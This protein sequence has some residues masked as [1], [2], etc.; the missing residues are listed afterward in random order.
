MST[1]FRGRRVPL[2]REDSGLCAES[3]SVH[4]RC[5]RDETSRVMQSQSNWFDIID[6]EAE[7]RRSPP[8]RTP[9]IPYSNRSWNS[10]TKFVS[11][12]FDDPMA[13]LKRTC[14]RLRCSYSS[15]WVTRHKLITLFERG[16][17]VRFL[18]R[19]LFSVPYLFR[20]TSVSPHV[21]WRIFLGEGSK[22][23]YHWRKPLLQSNMRHTIQVPNSSSSRFLCAFGAARVWSTSS[24]LLAGWI[25]RYFIWY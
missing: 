22:K 23:N 14:W 13:I 6:T 1:Y 21:G 10:R 3:Q 7:R 4:S 5:T 25:E 8:T 11:Q 18:S 17:V 12:L 16:T 15:V 20:V 24:D 19:Q 2:E 9:N